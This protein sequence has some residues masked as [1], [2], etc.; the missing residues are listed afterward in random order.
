MGFMERELERVK[1][2]LRE[3]QSDERYCHLYA[4]QQALSWALDPQGFAAPYDTIVNGKIQ[5]LIKDT[6]ADL[7]DCLVVHHPPA[8]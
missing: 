5:P 1:R 8:S 7:E 2:G 6:Q 4:A 3:P